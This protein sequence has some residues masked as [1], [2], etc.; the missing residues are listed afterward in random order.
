MWDCGFMADIDNIA[1]INEN[2][3]TVKTLLNSIRAQG[4]LNT[5]DVD[6]LLS[7]INS[8]LEK[9]NTEEDID[10]IKVFLTELKQ[11]LEERHNVL[12][13]KFGAIESL[14]SNLLKNS[15]ELPKSSELKE[16]FDIVATNLSVF[17]R[18]V[19]AQ[20]ESLT[21]IGMRLDA[22]RS[23]DS[24]KKD[25][26]KNIT[27]LKPDLERLSNG[28]DTIVLSLNDNFKTLAKTIS[29]IDQTAH[30]DKFAKSLEGMEIS[31][32]AL[33]SALQLLD[34]KTETVAESVKDLA[35]KSDSE[36]TE[37][38]LNELKLIN[39]D[40][41]NSID[42]INNRYT[43]IDNLSEKI[44]ASVNIIVNLRTMLEE[45]DNQNSKVILE[46]IDKLEGKLSEI[47][48]DTRFEEFK[49]SLTSILNEITKSNISAV[50]DITSASEKIVAIQDML[51]VLDINTNFSSVL[52]AI[53]S[54][55]AGI[56][57]HFDDKIQTFTN[58][59]E[60]NLNKI[61]S[62][63]SSNADSLN[64]R[65][66]QTQ[67]EISAICSGSFNTVF[68]NI[69]DLRNVV[70]QI[71]EN[72]VSASNAMFS[73]ISDRLT[74]FETALKESLESQ[75]MTTNE[76]SSKLCEQVEN[77]KNLS[78]VLDYKMDSSVV[79]ISNMTR[80][81]ETLKSSVDGMLALNFTDTVKDLRADIYAS[82]QDLVIALDSTGTELTDKVANDIYGKYEL[83]ISRIDS[84]EEEFN[85]VQNST[86]NYLKDVTEKL[87]ASV[88]DIISYVSEAKEFPL[89]EIS[90]E[91]DGI[92]EILKETNINYVENVRSIV[93][94]IRVQ[95][96]NKLEQL[97]KDS[98]K[99]TDFI[100]QNITANAEN[101]Q[102][103]VRNAY[104]K[105][106]EIKN[107]Y[108][109]IK[110]L[111]D[112][113]SVDST[114]R[115]DKLFSD[116]NNISSDMDN[117]LVALKSALLDKISE[118]KNEFA[119]ENADKVNDFRFSVENLYNKGSQAIFD[120]LENLK[121]RF[122]TLQAENSS[123]RVSGLDSILANLSDIKALINNFSSENAEMR[124]NA[125][126]NIYGDFDSIKSDIKDLTNE[127]SEGR[128]NNLDNILENI[129]N[130]QNLITNLAE[131]T[132]QARV[133]AFS[134]VYD[135]YEV[136]KTKIEKL[137]D[138]SSGA[139][140][141]ALAKLLDNFVGL[142]DYIKTLNTKTE[143]EL[144]Q[145][146]DSI[147]E[148]FDS[149]K[150]VLNKV[151][152]N[153]D[154][155]M[156]RQLSIIESN[157]ESL[158]SQMTIL[159]EK[160]EQS[161]VEKINSEYMN[162]SSRINESVAS[163]L[164]EY[165]SKIEE[166]FDDL[167][168][169]AKKQSDYMDEKISD[170]HSVMISVWA[171]QS[172]KNMRQIDEISE[173]LS[174]LLEENVKLATADY[175]SLK[176]YLN[177]FSQELSK[178]NELLAQ[179]F[180]AQLDDMTKYVD[181]VI[182]IQT[183]ESDAHIDEFSKLL[184]SLTDKLFAKSDEIIDGTN[185]QKELSLD[186]KDNVMILAEKSDNL[187]DKLSEWA[188]SVENSTLN[189]GS[190]LDE[191]L[192]E[193]K[194][195]D[196]EFKSLLSQTDN[197]I[198]K[199]YNEI[200]ENLS[201][202][203]SS[204]DESA[205]KLTSVSRETSMAELKAIEETSEKV[206]E[207]LELQKQSLEAVK[208]FISETMQS[209]L[210]EMSSEIEKET[211][212][213]VSE[214]VEQ[215]DAVKKSQEDAAIQITTGIES[216]IESQIYNNIED[217]K[218]Y[219]DVKTD[220]SVMTDKLDNLKIEITASMENVVSD[221]NKMLKSDVFTTALS[222]YRIANE[223]LV[224]SAADRI[225]EKIADFIGNSS[226]Q[227]NDLVG[228]GLK[229]VE[230]KLALF[231]KKFVD[232]LV[233]KYEEIKLISNKYNFSLDELKG[234]FEDIIKDF[235]DIKD[236]IN[237]QIAKIIE[238]FKVTSDSTNTEIRKL[239]ESF[240]HL[241]SQIS[242]KSFDEAFQASINKQI[243]SLE[244]LIKDQLSYI[245]DI[246]DL[247]GTNLPDVS[248]LNTLVKGVVIH[249]LEA[250]SDKIDDLCTHTDVKRNLNDLA[251]YQQNTAKRIEELGNR[252]DIQ[253]DL[254]NISNLVVSTADN[255]SEQ[256]ESQNIEETIETVINETKADLITQFLNIFNQ[257][258]FVAEQEE[259]IDYIQEKHDELIT[260]LSHLV[261]TSSDIDT[262]KNNLSTVDNKIN[263]L[264]DEIS[265]INEKITN[266]ISSDGDIDYV[267]SLQDLESD[268]ANLRIVLK[269]MKDNNVDYSGD[270]SNLMTSTE[271]V[272]KLVESIK[273]EL[274]DKNA[275]DNLTE[276]IVSISTRTNKLILASDESYKTLKDNLHDF[277]LIIDDL[278]ERT[279]NFAQESGMD[280]ID[281]KL[282]A[283]NTMMQKGAKTNQVFNEVF[284]YLAGW[285]DNAGKQIDSISD[286]VE[287]LDDIGQIKTM[288]TDIKAESEDNSENVELIE[289]L[290]N[291]FDKQAKKINAMETKIDKM[292]V[293]NTINNQKNKLDL[294]PM[295]DTLNKFLAAISEK[296]TTQQ[297]KINSLE[298]AL[299]KVVN[300][301][302]EKDTAQLTKKVGGM[303]RQIAKLNKSIEK[304]ASH[305]VEK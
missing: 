92:S 257:I 106:L 186:I 111:I 35:T 130:L 298:S 244:A 110:E 145:K 56:K 29:S 127:I 304:I 86:L 84:A 102:T 38:N 44:D 283:I 189:N 75:E 258:S 299:E 303:D 212:I 199:K 28:F 221:L 213:V 301:L 168:D 49:E 103:E 249:S 153:V 11:N 223:I 183:Q 202:L 242:N 234:S 20:K 120:V 57:T 239:F 253:K 115:Y 178:N 266:I 146:T 157:F 100:N 121:V 219:L 18:E 293:E 208:T 113:N 197:S 252:Y 210:K 77:I 171:S 94:V 170:I 37:R 295:E 36:Q 3:D 151:D 42:E 270:F 156:T 53:E 45:A 196:S 251:E 122:E 132:S 185:T 274:P 73:N 279:R 165:K 229:G 204:L 5:S 281:S 289:A 246:N 134:K 91:I 243:Y 215:F 268:I 6:K 263:S 305:V 79:E 235:K 241:R 89:D 16:L 195:K 32:N 277:K 108:E 61:L 70:S 158:I 76:A 285:V 10:L 48:N 30:L 125:L 23:D 187:T 25:I 163:K 191:I 58:L 34:K 176:D 275:F 240:E 201:V 292:I 188:L 123:E 66:N 247:C 139:R 184:E 67:S 180:K 166:T 13:S 126:A 52:T 250:L 245:E 224:N 160:A 95:V 282:N 226:T 101:I 41:N 26:I 80:M 107:L 117:K 97:E 4:I 162:I 148:C 62:N 9:I 2:F 192:S 124:G 288:L 114:T 296:M 136:I 287:I 15:N 206:I 271:N 99:R 261:T 300:I 135:D 131:Q 228:K 55:E 40:I 231:D 294:K 109:D 175:Q 71:D 104:D 248:E 214:L 255:L 65:I 105:L 119:C 256:I 265:A 87:S 269:E 50:K 64:S 54:S 88:M 262:V 22:I 260:I 137:A 59:S 96:E 232:T 7:G 72:G 174:A 259:I 267:Y 19:V 218:S 46:N 33:L 220:T 207:Q 200:K 129:N 85:K 194:E 164:E 140:T 237:L 43:K 51:K 276:D 143:N 47:N 238:E 222:D 290:S 193:I 179:N 39:Q 133:E 286:K 209:K 161:M 116:V 155:D 203:S 118:L 172:E 198:S 227:L 302:D 254:T 190:R 90:K 14:F 74:L 31:S 280:K 17:S 81:F 83:I 24:Q 82:K 167:T 236:D 169:R 12:V 233:D 142:K 182:D 211:D 284:E 177:E 144:I 297:E 264:K 217:L 147:M 273:D 150:A 68:E 159:N 230:N 78:N 154:G 216:I 60:A 112:A 173:K 8:K 63:I 1:V 141:S 69:A 225:N 21:D 93:D 181:S 138:E 205:E 98:A 27:L 272:Y 291:V 128:K 152:E 149:V 278:D